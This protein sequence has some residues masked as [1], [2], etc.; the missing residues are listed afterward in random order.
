MNKTIKL[1]GI[2]FLAVLGLL[3]FFELGK[4]EVTDWRKNFELNKKTPFGLYVFDQEAPSLLN[5]QL[6]KI[7]GDPYRYYTENT[8]KN[9]H[10]ILVIQKQIDSE[11]WV[12][13]LNEIQKGSDALVISTE[14]NT[15]VTDKL[16]FSV[17]TYFYKDQSQYV[18]TDKKLKTQLDLDKFP[19]RNSV[20]SIGKEIEILGKMKIDSV[21]WMA[22]FIKVKHGK[23]HLYYH[24]DPTFL[25]NYYL[26]KS[27]GNR[28]T[29]GVFSYLKNQETLWFVDPKMAKKSMSPLSF[30]LQNPSLRYAWWLL[31]VG[32][33]VF[34]I[35]GVKRKQRP[36]PIIEPLK[37]KSVEFIQSIGNLY[38]Q[39][40]DFHDMMGKKAQYFLHRI[41]MEL[42]METTQLDE[43]FEKKLLQKTGKPQEDIHNATML[44]K[45]ALDT[46]ATVTREEF[47]TMNRLLNEIYPH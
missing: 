40:G 2:I 10:N 42:L 7:E 30:I 19:G 4:K 33:L 27:D 1:Y 45:K 16:N 47:E 21:T 9:P 8:K 23:G 15:K 12:K 41:K 5:H 38:L 46:T 29:E 22:N 28:Y 34:V 14:C 26:L 31:W 18:L 25:T 13:I 44:I 35:F 32:T 43:N 20:G 6:K 24:T 37:N 36:V 11:S 39:E 3:A 17:E